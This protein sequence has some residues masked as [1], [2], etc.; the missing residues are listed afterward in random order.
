VVLS[1]FCENEFQNGLIA[2]IELVGKELAAYF[3][4]D[5]NDKNELSDDISVS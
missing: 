5:K 2:G 1:R 4:W 3:P